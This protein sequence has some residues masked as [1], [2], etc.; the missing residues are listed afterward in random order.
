MGFG[1]I[2]HFWNVA[3]D[4]ILRYEVCQKPGTYPMGFGVLT[5]RNGCV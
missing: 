1:C 4:A 3:Q 5:F 2:P